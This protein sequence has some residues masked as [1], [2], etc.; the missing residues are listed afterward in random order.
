MIDKWRVAFWSLPIASLVAHA[1]AVS[2]V[3]EWSRE[4]ERQASAYE[5]MEV[6]FVPV[7]IDFPSSLPSLLLSDYFFSRYSSIVDYSTVAQIVFSVIG[8][9]QYVIIS[10]GLVFL[11]FLVTKKYVKE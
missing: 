4:M 2:L 5:A 11:A 3:A 7:V 10:L 9:I 6:W 8:G 1:F